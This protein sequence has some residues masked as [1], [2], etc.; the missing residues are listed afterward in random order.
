MAALFYAD[1][2]LGVAPALPTRCAGFH[3]RDCPRS[4]AKKHPLPSS[5]AQHRLSWQEAMSVTQT[6]QSRLERL[7]S[8]LL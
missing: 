3:G 5:I 2:L 7:R 1:S 6:D 4:I 8:D